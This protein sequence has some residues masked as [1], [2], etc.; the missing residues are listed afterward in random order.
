MNIKKITLSALAWFCA[1]TISFAQDMESKASTS[2]FFFDANYGYTIRNAKTADGLGQVEN[3]MIKKIK[4]GG[5]LYL[6]AGY[7]INNRSSIGLVYNRFGFKGE[8]DNVTIVFNGV[9]ERSG[10]WTN[11]GN[12]SF[13]G[14]KYN[15]QGITP[16]QKGELMTGLGLGFLS[17]QEENSINSSTLSE[18][19]G[20]TIGILATV[21]Y[22]HFIGKNIA[23]GSRIGLISGTLSKIKTTVNGKTTETNLDDNEKESLGQ[24]NINAGLRVYF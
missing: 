23:I 24:F 16:N 7:K 17:Y 13:I 11:K 10:T 9:G 18:N 4:Q 6:E 3:D 2:K 19:K 22:Y 21:S 1:I 20:G 14:P 8:I 15:Y 12:I 5:N